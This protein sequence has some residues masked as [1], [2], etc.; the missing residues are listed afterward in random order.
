MAVVKSTH[1]FLERM[2][3]ALIS[4]S[5][6]SAH[7]RGIVG[8][9]DEQNATSSQQSM[10]VEHLLHRIRQVL[11]EVIHRDDIEAPRRKILFS[12]KTAVERTA[13]RLSREFR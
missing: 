6:N 12:D 7:E 9:Q 1:R 13:Q 8:S 2:Q 4:E 10:G 3:R 11:D 5:G